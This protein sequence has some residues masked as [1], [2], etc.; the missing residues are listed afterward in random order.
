MK[1]RHSL[2]GSTVG[3]FIFM[4]LIS[5]YGNE[6]YHSLFIFILFPILVLFIAI[7]ANIVLSII[8]IVKSPK[9]LVDFIPLMISI[10]TVVTL[11]FFPFSDMKLNLEVNTLQEERYQVIEMVKNNLIEIEGNGNAVVP[12]QYSK[13]SVDGEI[14]VYLN[15]G[16]DVVVGFWQERGVMS[17]YSAV[18]YSSKDE[19]LIQD[20]L[21]QI[22]ECRKLKD[23]WYYVTAE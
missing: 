23:H 11:I 3:V 15:E 5:W 21:Y 9:K 4:C 2:I 19:Q 7:I 13:V 12:S 1:W 14:I 22:K 20:N 17:G 6:L 10:L 16:E 18:V 8:Y